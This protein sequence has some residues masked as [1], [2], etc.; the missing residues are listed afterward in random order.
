MASTP[1]REEAIAE[2]NRQMRIF[3]I[4]EDLRNQGNLNDE[5]WRIAWE[6]RNKA[7]VLFDKAFGIH[8][9]MKIEVGEP[10]Y[11]LS[12]KAKSRVEQLKEKSD[13]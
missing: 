8:D 10:E 3:K 4:F 11:V 6:M 2:H 9:E 12:E 13:E 7:N 5:Y 1:E